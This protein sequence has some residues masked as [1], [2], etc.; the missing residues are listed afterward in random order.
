MY[1]LVIRNGTVVDGTGAAPRQA[2]VAVADGTIVAIGVV[3]G[4]AVRTIGATGRIVTPGF[5]DIHTHLDAQI[6]WDP[7]GTS[8]CFHG[9]TSVVIG[10]C[11]VTF[12]PCRPEDRQGLAEM[13][14]SV[15][16]IP[17]QAIMS[18]LSWEWE[19]YGQYLADIDRRPKGI[20][21]G[22]MVGHSA[23]R[24]YVMGD[25][26][27]EAPT[28]DDVAAM[29][30]LVEEAVGAGAL[31]LS[32][33]RTVLHKGADGEPIPGTY[34]TVDELVALAGV[35]GRAG[36]GVFETAAMLGSQNGATPESTIA[37]VAVLAEISRA[38][39]RPVSFGLTETIAGGHL[40]R[41][42]LELVA[43]ANAAG[44]DIHPQTTVRSVGVLFGLAHHSPFGGCPSWRALVD[45]P[46]EERLA[47]IR[48]PE[49][50]A[51]L[52]AEA[53][54]SE[55]I[56]PDRLF[57]LDSVPADY[58][59][60]PERSLAAR[61]EAAG[62][63]P[64]ALWI[65]LLD[66][67]DGAC[68]LNWPFLNQTPDEV[69]H[70]LADPNVVLGLADAGAHVGQIMDASQPTWFLAHWVRDRGLYGLAEG[71]ARL[72]S[73]PAEL[74]AIP[75]RG[76]L[77]EGRPADLNVI[78]LDHLALPLPEF[79]HDFPGGA[80]RWVQG[81]AGYDLTVVNGVVTVE[82]GEH[83]GALPGVTLRS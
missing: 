6:S 9:V 1:D 38:T 59:L 40:H 10:N 47:A 41:Q 81:A 50:R 33:S 34:A 14:E 77:A 76:V 42:V 13:M 58:R 45:L 55:G 28:D 83:T 46:F 67:T 22:G 48:D 71:V 44:A 4:E 12:A 56:G 80:G 35:L 36:K 23:L 73:I 2:D 32:S 16:D 70:L 74:F 60:D 66:A 25:R 39:G 18:G 82:A 57:P 3:E 68:L 78:D 29:I 72:T 53:D 64:A 21:I 7:L 11:G 65:D 5:V 30:E 54:A 61:A 8:S 79:H 20:N 62:T 17:A 75:D 27:T 51:V 15:E 26:A 52:V 37:E 24:R 43:E 63:T 49:Q 69:E 19:T 31:G